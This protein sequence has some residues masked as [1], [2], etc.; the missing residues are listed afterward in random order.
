MVAKQKKLV[1]IDGMALAYRG[2]F[3]LIRNPRITTYK[4]NTSAIYVFA[5][6]LIDIITRESPDAIAV[7][8]DTPEPT[9]RHKEYDEYK[10]TREKMP[11]ELAESLPYLDKL[12]G[13]FSIPVLRYPGWEADDV[14]GTLSTIAGV[15]GFDSIMVTPDKDYAQLVTNGAKIARPAKGGGLEYLDETRVCEEWG[16]ERIEQVID[17]LALMGDASDNIPGV[18]GIGKK[19]AQKLIALYGSVENIYEHLDELKGKQRENIEANRDIAT[20]SKHLVTIVTDVPIAEKLD[21]LAYSGWDEEALK[22]LFNELEFASIGSR[23]F[24]ASY[25]SGSDLGGADSVIADISTTDHVYRLI[26]TVEEID[27]LVNELVRQP[28][29]CFDLETTGLDEKTAEIVGMGF[30]W[31]PGTATFVRFPLEYTGCLD[32]FTPFFDDADITKVGHNLK[33]DLLVLRWHG[34]SVSGTILDTMIASYLCTP[35]ERRTMD[36]LSEQLLG[37]RPVHIEALIGE[38]GNEQKTMRDVPKEELC[39][40]G[41]EDADITLQL[42]QKLEPMVEEYGQHR[43]FYEIEC[44]L[45][46]V[47]VEM[48]HDGIRVDTGALSELSVSLGSE[49]TET[50]TRIEEL[51]GESFNLNSPKQLGDVLFDKLGLEPK[52]KRTKKT[53]QYVTNEQ[54]LA[55]LAPRYEVAEKIL[56]YR[57]KAK[58]KSTYVDMLP[59]AIFEGSGRVHTSY[60]Q[61]VTA[62]GRMQSH[63]PNLQNIPVRSEQGREI[64]KAFVSRDSDHLLLAADYSQ[65][66]LRIAAALSEEKAMVEAFED[67][68]DIHTSTSMRL[69]SVDEPEVTADMRR[70]AKTVNFGILYGISAFGLA[71]RSDLTR[72]EAAELINNYFAQYPALKI[73]QE[74]TIEFARENGYV[75]TATGRR[76]YM[77][78]INSRNATIRSATERNAINAPIQGSAAD[79]IKIAMSKIMETF[80]SMGCK[81]RMLLQVHD[82]LVFDLHRDEVDTIPQVV[83][84]AME[85]A[86]PLAVPIVVEYGIGE[87]WLTAH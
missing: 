3:A 59:G 87:N 43:V 67:G 80:D 13:A 18:P 12:C 9:H 78:E 65:I 5:N 57:M 68:I 47:L 14:I 86:L 55:R 26:E 31:K 25:E 19:T 20:L 50:A 33:Y 64:R 77:K 48:E 11:E 34:K 71:E 10:K 74:K 61:A 27:V 24:G 83:K 15:S 32:R 69:F 4:L 58:L 56:E 82:E 53:G 7:A 72:S 79:M 49:I 66:E 51:A 52:P 60:E 42:W 35:D 39:E 40:Y 46:P 16:I 8:F 38:K 21:D 41:A 22:N 30:S 85:K 28:L 62:T 17:I 2:F 84:E 36:S 29:V 73:W 70:H 6:V 44:P 63:D 75:E 37:Y 23:M 81:T 76:R 54:V 1:L 45:I